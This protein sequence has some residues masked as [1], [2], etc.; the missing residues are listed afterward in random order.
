MASCEKCGNAFEPRYYKGVATRFCS[1]RCQNSVCANRRHGHA[2]GSRHSP[3]HAAWANM[4]ARC[5]PDHK[6]HARYFDRGIRICERWQV[7]DCF[8]ADMGERPSNTSLDRR[9]NDRGY[10]P[11]N[12]RWATARQQAQNRRTTWL[13]TYR[14]KTQPL[15]EWARELGV[16][17]TRISRAIK[18]LGSIEAAIASVA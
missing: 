16:T 2:Q 10:E 11:D 4:I 6:D 7:F 5:Q 17:P 13:I 9:K 15:I 3:T 18:R 8:L 14:D 12:C 1:R